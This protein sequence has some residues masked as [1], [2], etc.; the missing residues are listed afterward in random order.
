[1]E[2]HPAVGQVEGLAPEP[3]LD[4]DGVAGDDEG[5]QVGD[6]VVHDPAVVGARRD[7]EGL[8]EVHGPGRVDGDQLDIGGVAAIGGVDAVDRGRGGRLD[9]GREGAGQLQVPPDRLEVEVGVE[10]TATHGVRLAEVAL[11]GTLAGVSDDVVQWEADVVLSDGG[12]MHV[13]PIR[14]DDGD[15]LAHVPRAPVARE[16]LLPLLQPPAPADLHRTSSG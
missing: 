11:V 8:V 16:H 12:T 14:P 15:L 6:G 7:V 2:G 9:R 3:G 1:M 5:G 13:R 10:G 4:V